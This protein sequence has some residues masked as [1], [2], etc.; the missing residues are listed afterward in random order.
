MSLRPVLLTGLTLAIVAS[1]ESLLCAEATDKLDPRKRTTGLSRELKAQ[2]I[3]NL[4]SGLIGGL[5]VTQV[6]VR[7]STNIQSGAKSRLSA[8]FHGVL[9]LVCA[10]TI[11][12]WLNLIPLASLAAILFVVGYKLAHPTK[13]VAMY[14]AGWGQCLPFLITVIAILLTDLLRGIGIGMAASVFFIL[15]DNFVHSYWLHEQDTGNGKQIRLVLSEHVSFL[16]KGSIL[17]TLR[18]IPPHSKVLIDASD[19]VLH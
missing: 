14:K 8:L 15:R 18:E 12:N 19:S 2:G 3:G 13:F 17:K 16:N 5:P 10:A 6:I 11:A 1:L 7:S 4:V 9:L